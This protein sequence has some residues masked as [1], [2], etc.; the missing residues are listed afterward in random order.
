MKYQKHKARSR[1][2][3]KLRLRDAAIFLN[4][5]PSLIDFQMLHYG[6]HYWCM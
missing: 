6:D 2:T 1:K 3:R 4:N 5:Q